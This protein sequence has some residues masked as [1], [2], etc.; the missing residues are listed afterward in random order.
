MH[1]GTGAQ[2]LKMSAAAAEAAA[3][4]EDDALMAVAADESLFDE[5]EGG[6]GAAEASAGGRAPRPGVR[7]DLGSVHHPSVA[8]ELTEL[9]RRRTARLDAFKRM[10]A[11]AADPVKRFDLFMRGAGACGLV[12]AAAACAPERAAAARAHNFTGPSLPASHSLVELFT[13]YT[14]ETVAQEQA[15]EAASG[16]S[17]A[18]AADAPATAKA[19]GG[20]RGSHRVTEKEEDAVRLGRVGGRHGDAH[21]HGAACTPVV[22]HVSLRL[23][24]M[25]RNP[26]YSRSRAPPFHARPLCPP[27]CSQALVVTEAADPARVSRVLAQPSLIAHGTMREYQLEG[28]NWMIS[29]HDRGISGILADEM[30]LG[31]TLQSISLLAWAKESRKVVGPHLVLVP[32]SVMGNWAREFA[33]WAPSLRVFKLQGADKEERTRMVREE[34]VPGKWDVIICSF[35][36]LCIEHSSLRKLHWYYIVVDEAHRIKNEKSVLAV[37]V[38]QQ[39]SEFRL[40]LTGTP[41]QNNLHELWALLNFLLPDL[42]SSSEEF[43]TYFASGALSNQDAVKK[44][45][46]ILRPFLLRRLKSDVE[47]SLLPKIETK[48]FIGMSPV[49]KQWYKAVLSKDVSALNAIGG[50]DRSRLLNIL[51]Q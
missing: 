13:T 34:L 33:R 22:V 40:L 6:G 36:T 31:K 2:T 43:D 32:K 48:L 16:G 50:T 38:R 23:S 21:A 27:C 39:A 51:M 42:F 19:G 8:P 10:S 20:K 15:A 35:E 44:L 46:A 4:D 5:D 24:R 28:L 14:L 12:A 1:S 7:G 45:H 26:P 41:L 47:R 17:A 25:L 37:R 9:R 18:A 11:A 3:S 29:L 49:Q 30:G